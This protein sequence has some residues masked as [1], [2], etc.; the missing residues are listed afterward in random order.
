MEQGETDEH[1]GRRSY[2][3]EATS[4][5]SRVCAEK[6][7]YPESQENGLLIQKKDGSLRFCVDY[8]KLNAATKSDKFP[9][10]WIHDL[11]DQLSKSQLQTS[12]PL[13]Y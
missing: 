4:E 10:P 5:V 11:L 12:Q 2:S 6:R 8:C 1:R 7:N 3:N 13:G 9:L